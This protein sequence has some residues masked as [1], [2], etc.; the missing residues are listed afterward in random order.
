MLQLMTLPFL[1][2]MLQLMILQLQKE[3][4][5]LMILLLLKEML[6]LMILLLLKEKLQLMILLQMKL[7]LIPP[8]ST[9]PITRTTKSLSSILSSLQQPKISQR[10]HPKL[11]PL[12][13]LLISVSMRRISV[14]P[15]KIPSISRNSPNNNNK[16]PSQLRS[17]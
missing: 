2:E 5:Q 10:S 17:V 6:Q 13:S 1:K 7:Q 8:N 15:T 11:K 14:P 16:K 12:L 3:M 4:L 9:S